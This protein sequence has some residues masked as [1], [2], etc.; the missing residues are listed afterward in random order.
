MKKKLDRK[1][2]EAYLALQIEKVLTKDQILEAYLNRI[3][4]GQGAYGVQ[5]AAQTYFSKD[6]EDLTIAESAV[7][8]G[9][10]KSPSKYA[11]F[12][13]LPPE[14]LIAKTC[15]SWSNRHLRRKIYCCI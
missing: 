8:A 11:L 14:N 9:I 5:E 10:I 3:F 13:T 15:R 7:L 1:I 4:L 12:K 6:V 2:K